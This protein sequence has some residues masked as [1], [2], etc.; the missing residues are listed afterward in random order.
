MAASGA[1]EVQFVIAP[2]AGHSSTIERPDVV[3][4]AIEAFLER[5]WPA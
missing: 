3:N 4:A 1:R 2:G 5:V